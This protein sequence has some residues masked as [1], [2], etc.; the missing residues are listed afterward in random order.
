[1][2]ALNNLQQTNSVAKYLIH[3]AGHSQHAKM[4]GHALA[5]YLYRGLK[6]VIKDLLAGQE[7]WKTF[8]ELHD[9]ASRPDARLQARKIEKEQEIR[10]RAAPPVRTQMKSAFDP[11]PAF[12]PRPAFTPATR[13]TPPTAPC[14]FPPASG[15][16]GATPM[17]LDSQHRRMSQEEHNRCI[18]GALCFTCKKSGPMSRECSKKRMRIAEIELE[19]EQDTQRLS[20]NHNAQE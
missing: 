2:A 12:T 7:E 3:F 1:M 5:L 10:T 20:E 16:V 17:E 8:E 14:L 6:D 18:R 15:H 11:K 4:D 19:L 13:R 9:R